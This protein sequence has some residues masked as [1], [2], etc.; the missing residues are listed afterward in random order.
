MDVLEHYTTY[1]SF[2][3]I[4]KSTEANPEFDKDQAAKKLRCYVVESRPE[5]VAEEGRH[6]IMSGT[7][8]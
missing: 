8:S 1:D 4:I 6:R 3:K 2:Y 7:F 5:T